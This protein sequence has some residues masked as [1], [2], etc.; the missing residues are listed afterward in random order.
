MVSEERMTW[1]LGRKRPVRVIPAGLVRDP[2]GKVPD[3]HHT[4]LHRL[5][6]PEPAPRDH[7]HAVPGHENFILVYPHGRHQEYQ[8]DPDHDHQVLVSVSHPELF[9]PHL[10]NTSIW[11]RAEQPREKADDLLLHPNRAAQNI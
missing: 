8:H 1:L 6:P 4:P 9:G 11:I 5:D 2:V 3:E 10:A 7:P